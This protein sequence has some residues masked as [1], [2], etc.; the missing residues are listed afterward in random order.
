MLL[1]GFEIYYGYKTPTRFWMSFALIVTLSILL[2]QV[3]RQ[4]IRKRLEREEFEG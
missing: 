1:L 3:V 2:E 4:R